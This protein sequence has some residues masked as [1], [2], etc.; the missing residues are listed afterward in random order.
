MGRGTWEMTEEEGQKGTKWMKTGM[1]DCTMGRMLWT[2]L[3][4]IHAENSQ[5]ACEQLA[6][7][8]LSFINQNYSPF[9]HCERLGH[10]TL[11]TPSTW[12]RSFNGRRASGLPPGSGL[13]EE[14]PSAVNHW[15]GW[16]FP[17]D[18]LDAGSSSTALSPLNITLYWVICYCRQEWDVA[19][20]EHTKIFP[21]WFPLEQL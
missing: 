2:V 11:S 5:P 3:L 20:G 6:W 10:W 16:S 15:K 19:G 1:W 8:H 14:S 13:L 4:S 17:K 7:L 9:F 18:S 12:Q 21:F